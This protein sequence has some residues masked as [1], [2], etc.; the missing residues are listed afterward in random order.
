MTW[1]N[2]WLDNNENMARRSRNGFFIGIKMV[3]WVCVNY[4]QQ[5]N[6]AHAATL[7]GKLHFIKMNVNGT[8]DSA[9]NTDGGCA[10]IASAPS[11]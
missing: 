7:F 1:E 9:D 2:A 5:I 10:G 8:T 3:L 11:V 6:D 4:R